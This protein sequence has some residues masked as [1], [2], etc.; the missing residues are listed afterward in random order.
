MR[1]SIIVG[2]GF[3][4]EGKGI[5]TDYLCSNAKKPIVIRHNGGQQAGHTVML[6]GKKHVFSNYGSGSLRGAPTYLSKYCTFFLNTMQNERDKLMNL[7]I[8]P[9]LFIHPLAKV[10]TPYDV[11][12][13]RWNNSH[14]H[15]TV[16][17]GVGATMHRHLKTGYKLH[18]MDLE[19]KNVLHAKLKSIKQYYEDLVANS[20]GNRMNPRY[21]TIL[22]PIEEYFM[23]CL[24]EY[25][26]AVEEEHFLV[27]DF[28]DLVFEGA[29]GILLDM[30]HG[31]FPNVTYSST[32]SRNAVKMLE[33]MGMEDEADIYYITRCYQTRHGNGWMSNQSNIELINNQEEINTH[34]EFQGDFKI[35]ELDYSLLNYSLRCDHIYSWHPAF[36]RHLVVTCLDQR[37]NFEFDYGKLNTEFDSIIRSYSPYSKDMQQEYVTV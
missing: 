35:G 34:N 11:A 8:T 13:N 37:E 7:G 16:G 25:S 20:T 15:G 14:G 32:T 4:D 9:E 26:F 5:T 23:D 10:T 19:Y 28:T 1:V 29:Q 27:T 33:G 22:K 30:D 17:L 18:A 2:L 21:E 36:R 6:D 12:W 3:G 24:D 31:I